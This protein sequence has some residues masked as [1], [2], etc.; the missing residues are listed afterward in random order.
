MRPGHGHQHGEGW[1]PAYLWS[2]R[3]VSFVSCPLPA[4]RSYLSSAIR[5]L[6][7]DWYNLIS[8][9]GLQVNRTPRNI[10]IFIIQTLQTQNGWLYHGL[11][12]G[13]RGL[14]WGKIIFSHPYVDC[15]SIQLDSSPLIKSFLTL[16][17]ILPISTHPLNSMPH[18]TFLRWRSTPTAPSPSPASPPSS[19]VAFHTHHLKLKCN[20][21]AFCKAF[22]NKIFHRGEK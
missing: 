17:W 7:G 13:R 2:S 1:S 22:G 15:F 12:G 18:S 6:L 10:L 11:W 20:E 16:F 9:F 14:H 3:L 8:L 4:P 19:L 21:V 5:K